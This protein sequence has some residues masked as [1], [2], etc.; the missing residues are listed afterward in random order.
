MVRPCCTSFSQA[1]TMSLIS[2]LLRFSLGFLGVFGS[3]GAIVA[4]AARRYRAGSNMSSIPLVFQRLYV[5]R[6]I[7]SGYPCQALSNRNNRDDSAD[8]TKL[9]ATILLSIAEDGEHEFSIL[10]QLDIDE[11]CYSLVHYSS[12]HIEPI[13]IYLSQHLFSERA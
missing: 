1:S 5:F 4:I 3:V 13:T 10:L 6:R 12:T 11:Q 2:G 8:G 9:I 7:S